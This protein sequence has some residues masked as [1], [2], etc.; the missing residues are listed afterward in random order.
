MLVVKFG[1]KKGIDE[2]LYSINKKKKV[3]HN[4]PQFRT[5]PP[6]EY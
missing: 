4:K 3:W 2:F 1:T 6:G 5:Y